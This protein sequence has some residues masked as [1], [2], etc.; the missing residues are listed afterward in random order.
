MLRLLPPCLFAAVLT[1]PSVAQETEKVAAKP[2]AAVAAPAQARA[3]AGHGFVL[4]AGDLGLEDLIDAAAQVLGRNILYTPAEFQGG[5]KAS[6][7]TVHLQNRLELD[8]NG[9]EEM[10][11][12]LL[13]A[14]GYA[15]TPLDPGRNVYE[16]IAMFG[17]RGKEISTRAVSMTPDEV[18]RRPM[19]RVVV[20]TTL[21]LQHINAPVAVNALR[22][23]YGQAGNQASTLQFGNVGNNRSLLLEGFADQVA[24]AIRIIRECDKPPPPEHQPELATRV[25]QLEQQAQ[26]LREQLAK[27]ADKP[28]KPQ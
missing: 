15:V 19:L 17:P 21:D 8:A 18:L 7:P 4:E 26:S 11:S 13:Y 23:F 28:E 3:V 1:S 24:A 16:V 12:S 22:P 14:R 2:P 20:L 27:K 9:C 5:G 10:L 25:Q 6:A